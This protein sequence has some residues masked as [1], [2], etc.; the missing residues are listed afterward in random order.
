MLGVIA[1]IILNGKCAGH[2]KR[3]V[4]GPGRIMKTTSTAIFY[5][6]VSNILQSNVRLKVGVERRLSISWPP[7]AA[8]RG[9]RWG[10][11]PPTYAQAHFW[12]SSKSVNFF[13]GYGVGQTW[14]TSWS[15]FLSLK[16]DK[17]FKKSLDKVSREPRIIM[18]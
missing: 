17:N 4:K 15:L 5:T 16:N 8:P 2:G 18:I 3:K 7:V 1:S 12:K 6:M 11:S 13:L 9:G 14:T 10:T